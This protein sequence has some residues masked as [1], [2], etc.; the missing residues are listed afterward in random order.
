[1]IR[2]EGITEQLRYLGYGQMPSN[3]HLALA[4]YPHAEDTHSVSQH[5]EIE[6]PSFSPNSTSLHW[7]RYHL[8]TPP[9]QVPYITTSRAEERLAS[10][11]TSTHRQTPSF[12]IPD[13]W[14]V[15]GL[16]ETAS[17]VMPEMIYQE[18]DFMEELDASE[19]PTFHTPFASPMPQHSGITHRP[20]LLDFRFANSRV[21]TSAPDNDMG[22]AP[23]AEESASIA[24]P[25]MPAKNSSTPKRLGR[26][27]KVQCD[28]CR[29]AKRN[30]EV[31][32]LIRE[33]LRS[34]ANL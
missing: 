29:L 32:I 9:S 15:G 1:M 14:G 34:S 27:G 2:E 11:A 19:R 16:P 7:P 4:A 21:D 13:P 10:V 25:P 33:W 24:T 18:M 23:T 3:L 6:N 12:D 8:S 30:Y 31:T 20:E 26:R 17:T 5:G 22:I 28:P